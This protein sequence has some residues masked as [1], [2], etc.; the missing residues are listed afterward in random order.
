[1][2]YKNQCPIFPKS[3]MIPP[4][5]TCKEV[6]TV[7]SSDTLYGISQTFG[8]P[9]PVLMQVNRILNP[10]ALKIGMKLC[11]PGAKDAVPPTCSGTYHVI[12]EGDT[13]YMIAKKYKLPLSAI[14]RANPNMDPYDLQVGMKLCIPTMPVEETPQNGMDGG[15]EGEMEEEAGNE[16]EEE[17]GSV[18]PSCPIGNVY[19]T[20]RGDTLSRILERF[21]MTYETLQ[22][23]NPNIDFSKSLDGL[24]LC[25]PG[26]MEKENCPLSDAYFVKS[27]DSLDSIS[28]KLLIVSDS[29]LISNPKLTVTDF[30]VPGTKICIPK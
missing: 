2:A 30:S 12:V 1:M 22:N 13:L 18:A 28:Q 14:I 17:N 5:Y 27:G 16:M 4:N 24:E 10:Y 7:K 9:V 21:G 8:V 15:M 19:Q 11:I 20:Q 29:L 26:M 3:P 23:A 6:Y 25:I